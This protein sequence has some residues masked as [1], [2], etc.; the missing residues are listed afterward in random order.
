MTKNTDI[1]AQIVSAGLKYWQVAES[2]GV[3]SE[4]FSK[5]LRF[6]LSPERKQAIKCAIEKVRKESGN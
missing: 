3:T 6:E 2:I 4:T 1:K 5:W